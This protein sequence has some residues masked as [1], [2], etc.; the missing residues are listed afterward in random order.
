D[1]YIDDVWLGS[2]DT[3]NLELAAGSYDIDVRAD[4]FLSGRRTIVLEAAQTNFVQFALIP[5]AGGSVQVRTTPAA[6][7]Y[8]AGF[9]YGASPVTI[10]VQAGEHEVFVF[11]PG[12]SPETHAVTVKDFRVSRLDVTLTP[13]TDNL[14]YW[15]APAGFEVLINGELRAGYLP[16]PDAGTYAIEMRRSGRSIRFEVVLEQAGIFELDLLSRSLTMLEP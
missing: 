9:A 8:L 11:R 13:I 12:F 6:E 16:N 4:N 7:I 10:P 14:L 3:V 2:G 1:I 5:A 15:Q